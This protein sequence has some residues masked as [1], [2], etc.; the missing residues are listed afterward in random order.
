MC[1]TIRTDAPSAVVNRTRSKMNKGAVR[2]SIRD[3][4]GVRA[5][6]VKDDTDLPSP[7]VSNKKNYMVFVVEPCLSS[8]KERLPPQHR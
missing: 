3:K 4:K 7:F 2:V 6:I 8:G 5:C 1:T